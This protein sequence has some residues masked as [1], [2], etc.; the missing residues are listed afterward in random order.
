MLRALAKANHNSYSIK[1]ENLMGTHYLCRVISMR[2][3]H[4]SLLA[5]LI[6][7][8]MTLGCGENVT[9]QSAAGPTTTDR[10]SDGHGDFHSHDAGPH[11]GSLADWGGGKFHVEFAVDH[12][13]QQATVYILSS[14]A[15]T[16]RSI[17][18]EEIQLSI[19]DPAM[20][21]TLKASP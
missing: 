1:S 16:L 18:A 4:A 10:P 17:G 12:I 20:E 11:D 5:V 21:V 14:D 19:K 7:I 3:C 8:F 15:K 6:P 13:E 9:Q 2:T